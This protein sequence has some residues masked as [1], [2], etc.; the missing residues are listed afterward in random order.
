VQVTSPVSHI[1]GRA[2]YFFKNSILV[3]GHESSA[4][5]PAR[6]ILLEPLTLK[7][8]TR[9]WEEMYPDTYV[10]LQASS[11]YVVFRSGSEYRLGRFDEAL[12]LIS[13]SE[14]SVDKDSAFFLFGDKIYINSADRDVLVLNREDL[15]REGT[16]R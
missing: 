6:L 16:I 15:K 2:Y 8:T 10:L 7:E 3:V 9:S 11:I 13:Q 14:Q 4:T 5:S 12:Q 1:R